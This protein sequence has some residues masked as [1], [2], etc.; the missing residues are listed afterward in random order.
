MITSTLKKYTLLAIFSVIACC[1]KAQ[2][3][4]PLPR[5]EVGAGASAFVYMG[6]LTTHRLGSIETIRPGALAFVNYNLTSRWVLQA[7][8]AAGSIK[9][10][11]AECANPAFR[12]ERNFAFSSSVRELSLKAQYN[13]F[14]SY[15]VES[16]TLSP[17]ISGGIAVDFFNVKIDYS[18]LTT[19]LATEE[20]Q[21]VAGLQADILNGTPKKLFSIP[22][23]LG[24][25]KSW[26]E[27][28]DVFTEANYR[29]GF[30]DY[31][32]GF[33]QSVAS[34]TKDQFYS[35]NIGLIY[36]FQKG[37]NLDCPRF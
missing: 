35:V 17:Y 4:N 28:W 34:K 1:A 26:S 36:K 30:S 15:K 21:I 24:V 32:D 33:S 37:S 14:N 12:R 20:P 10:D 2:N 19:K 9:G 11:D 25:R 18:R 8:L 27:K 16:T 13:L 7:G 5:W 6:D 29:L 3:N 22:I 31:I 23:T